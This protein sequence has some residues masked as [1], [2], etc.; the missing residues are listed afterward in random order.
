M[1][2][3]YRSFNEL[4]VRTA[5]LNDLGSVKGRDRECLVS[6]LIL[7]QSSNF[8]VRPSLLDAYTQRNAA[9]SATTS[10]AAP[11]C[12]RHASLTACSW[13]GVRHSRKRL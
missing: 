10:G 11:P 13:A 6:K 12:S 5:F 3:S 1:V 7:E 9:P 4:A 8:V 2:F